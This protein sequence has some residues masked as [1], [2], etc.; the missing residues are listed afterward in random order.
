MVVGG[1]QLSIPVDIPQTTI[2]VVV[3]QINVHL[4]RRHHQYSKGHVLYTSYSFYTCRAINVCVCV[5]EEKGGEKED[6]EE[7]G[8]NE[9][10]P[11]LVDRRI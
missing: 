9:F 1:P 7:E 5:E 2:S 8:T 6:G 11:T 10:I 3:V 4:A